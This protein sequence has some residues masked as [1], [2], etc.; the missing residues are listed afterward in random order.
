M[1]DEK[2]LEQRS[3]TIDILVQEL[4]IK[5]K[6]LNKYRDKIYEQQ[7][8][9]KNKNEHIEFYKREANNLRK[10]LHKVDKKVKKNEL[11]IAYLEDKTKDL[12]GERQPHDPFYAETVAEI[13]ALK[14]GER[15]LQKATNRK[16]TN[17]KFRK[18]LIN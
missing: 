5:Q 8:V 11:H 3:M 4:Q 18:T 7:D 10:E 1:I 13:R 6:R 16:K 9:L 14:S 2:K 12:A 17:G 15:P